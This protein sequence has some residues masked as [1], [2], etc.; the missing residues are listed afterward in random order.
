MFFSKCH[1]IS[2]SICRITV[3]QFCFLR[4]VSFFV[5]Y[6]LFCSLPHYPNYASVSI[7]LFLPSWFFSFFSPLPRRKPIHVSSLAASR[8]IWRPKYSVKPTSCVCLALT[9]PGYCTKVWALPGGV[10]RYPLWVLNAVPMNYKRLSRIWL[11]FRVITASLEI[12][13]A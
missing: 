2:I 12:T 6:F 7:G 9:M 10:Q 1:S 4:F 8:R 5:L 13:S 3:N 11:L